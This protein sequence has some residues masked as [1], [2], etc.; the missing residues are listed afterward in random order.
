MKGACHEGS[1]NQNQITT[2]KLH[3]TRGGINNSCYQRPV[4][5]V[6]SS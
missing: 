2:R 6:P 4:T 5:V 3:Q 1:K